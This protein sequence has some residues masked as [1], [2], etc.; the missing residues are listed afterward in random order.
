LKDEGLT[1]DRVKP[2]Y[3]YNADFKIVEC[4][5]IIKSGETE[6]KKE[7]KLLVK[8]DAVYLIGV[9]KKETKLEDK[10]DSSIYIH[11]K[12]G[13]TYHVD[14]LNDIPVETYLDFY[15]TKQPNVIT[16]VNKYG[17]EV[18]NFQVGEYTWTPKT[19]TGEGEDKVCSKDGYAR[20]FTTL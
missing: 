8:L 4:S 10:K 20:I 14:N 1:A 12:V 18:R 7:E 5:K 2:N 3:C 6:I 11:K 15:Y 17:N 16:H 19:C 13:E 9:D